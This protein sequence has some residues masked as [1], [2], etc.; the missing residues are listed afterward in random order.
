MVNRILFEWVLDNFNAVS[1]ALNCKLAYSA[2]SKSSLS[3]REII[4]SLLG[5]VKRSSSMDLIVPIVLVGS[6][7]KATELLSGH[8][9]N[10]FSLAN[11]T[12]AQRQTIKRNDDSLVFMMTSGSEIFKLVICEFQWKVKFINL[13]HRSA[14]WWVEC[15]MLDGWSLNLLPPQRLFVAGNK[16][17]WA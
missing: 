13:S 15:R 9:T 12:G 8:S 2:E 11:A 14:R 1:L 17:T 6:T 10:T 3:P 7:C 16:S 5:I 4:C